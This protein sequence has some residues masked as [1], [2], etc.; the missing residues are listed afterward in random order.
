MIL[1]PG[2]HASTFILFISI[3]MATLVLVLELEWLMLSWGFPFWALLTSV[4]I[5]LN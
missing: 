3:V 4:H 5:N 2:Q 1:C